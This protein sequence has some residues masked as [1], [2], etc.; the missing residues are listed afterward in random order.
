[1]TMPISP[2]VTRNAVQALAESALPHAPVLAESQRSR[3]SRIA[4]V[5]GLHAAAAALSAKS[6]R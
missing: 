4:V 5:R 1:M 3:P 6:R 2:M